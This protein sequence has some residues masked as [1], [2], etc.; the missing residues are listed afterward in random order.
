MLI[1]GKL[2]AGCVRRSAFDRDLL[3]DLEDREGR[4]SR[5]IYRSTDLHFRPKIED[6][7]AIPANI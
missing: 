3:E 1:D 6:S 5:L 7:G 2:Q 4:N